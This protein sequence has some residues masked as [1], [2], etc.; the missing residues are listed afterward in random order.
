MNKNDKIKLTEITPVYYDKKSTKKVRALLVV[1]DGWEEGIEFEL[2][3]FPAFIGRDE[4]CN[5]CIPL[6][7]VSRQHAVISLT[8]EKFI[9]RD[10]K[11]TNGTYLNNR[12]ITESLL[13]H[14]DEIT[15]GEV[16][17]KFV[18]EEKK[19]SDRVYVIESQ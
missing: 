18:V 19:D 1:I 9:I 4:S 15:V 2:D 7:S 11:S 6:P 17:L 12:I 8:D 5:V 16:T 14:G 3:E 10:Q 13:K